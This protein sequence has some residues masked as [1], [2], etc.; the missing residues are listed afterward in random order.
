M[1]LFRNIRWVRHWCVTN[2]VVVDSGLGP[3]NPY[4]HLVRRCVSDSQTLRW[5]WLALEK[6]IKIL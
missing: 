4:C 5:V 1:H 2:P 6:H 3:I